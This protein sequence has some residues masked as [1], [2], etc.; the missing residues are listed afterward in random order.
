M[1]TVI[2]VV[3]AAAALALATVNYYFPKDE[4]M[5]NAETN[6]LFQQSQKEK[7]LENVPN[8]LMEQ[9]KELTQMMRKIQPQCTKNP[10]KLNV[11][12]GLFFEPAFTVV[13]GSMPLD[14]VFILLLIHTCGAGL[15]E[16]ISTVCHHMSLGGVLVDMA[17]SLILAAYAMYR[18]KRGKAESVKR[19][20]QLQKESLKTE[21]D[22]EDVVSTLMELKTELENQRG[23][24][25]ELLEEVEGEQE[26]NKQNLQAVEK[27]IT[28]REATFDKPEELLREKEDLLR[29]QWK[30]DQTKRDNERQLL[31]TE[32]LLEPIEIQVN[33]LH[34][35]KEVDFG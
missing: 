13:S 16:S 29:A 15:V 20:A 11:T 8:I 32:R 10:T 18:W 14:T 33:K 25:K 4:K 27:E 21:E 5:V 30:L 31:N 19:N 35:K 3:A 24:L 2:S 23:R 34:R 7:E 22:G 9:E 17:L 26:V 28:E 6:P 1:R 12:D